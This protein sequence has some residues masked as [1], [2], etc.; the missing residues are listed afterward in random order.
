MHTA[1]YTAPSNQTVTFLLIPEYVYVFE[2]EPRHIVS[3]GKYYSLYRIKMIDRIEVYRYSFTPH[4]Y[5]PGPTS[6]DF[7]H[8]LQMVCYDTIEVMEGDEESTD[9]GITHMVIRYYNPSYTYT[10]Y[11]SSYTTPASQMKQISIPHSSF[12]RVF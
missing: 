1:S 9:P 7:F 12:E 11:T 10:R 4:S 2:I 6:S 8:V 3:T 5:I